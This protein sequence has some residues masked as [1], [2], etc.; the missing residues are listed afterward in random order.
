[1]RYN[2]DPRHLARWYALQ[3]TFNHT[4]TI[5]DPENSLVFNEEELFEIDGMNENEID[6]ELAD[7]LIKGV[8]ESKEEIN[9]II[10]KLAPE[11][12]INQIS[13]VD[14]HILYITIYEGF[15]DKITPPKVAIDEGIKF[16]KEFR[17]KA[18]A[19]FSN[20]VLGTLIKQTEGTK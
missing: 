14:L 13:K 7:K 18:S 15:I 3:N 16:A 20:G 9:E 10:L 2:K 8:K 19:K 4:F 5:D 17:G 1:M 11:R 12:P 6:K